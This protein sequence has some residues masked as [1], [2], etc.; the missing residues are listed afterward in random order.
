MNNT[1]GC[2]LL[3]FPQIHKTQDSQSSGGFIVLRTGA[4]AVGK[5]R[6]SRGCVEIYSL[7]WG[8]ME[9]W[10]RWHHWSV[11]IQKHTWVVCVCICVC[12]CMWLHSLAYACSFFAVDLQ[13]S[14]TRHQTLNLLFLILCQC[15][16][17][18]KA[19]AQ[20]VRD[21][22]RLALYLKVI[23]N[24]WFSSPHSGVMY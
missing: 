4:Q 15:L 9:S 14:G 13:H 17:L 23:W 18:P 20:T 21:N 16:P 11:L 10:M 19:L 2:P 22:L 6:K 12:P 8:M 7:Y 24:S 1:Q 5:G 3:L